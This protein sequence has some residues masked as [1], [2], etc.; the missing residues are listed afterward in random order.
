MKLTFALFLLL[1]SAACK[2]DSEEMY[3]KDAWCGDEMARPGDAERIAKWAAE[4][5]IECD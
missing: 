3:M 1:C 4:H 5:K 2:K